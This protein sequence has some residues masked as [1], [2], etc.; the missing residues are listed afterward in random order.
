ML[1]RFVCHVTEQQILISCLVD[2]IAIEHQ[3]VLTG[4]YLNKNC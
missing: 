1:V 4:E 2:L 3:M